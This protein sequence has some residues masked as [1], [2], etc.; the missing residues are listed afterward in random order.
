MRFMMLLRSDASAESGALPD[1]K[2]LTDMTHYN[3]A[4]ADAGV[5]VGA[6]G[7]HPTSRGA[8]IR[9]ANG[10]TTVTD[11]PFAESKEV[12][13]GFFMLKTKSLDE[14]IS[15]AKRMPGG[16]S[17][18]EGRV[19]LRQI[20][21]T[22]DFPV[23]PAEKEGGWRDEELAMR[24]DP[25]KSSPDKGKRYMSFLIA[26]RNTEAEMMPTEKVLSEMGALVG[27]M[28]EKGVLISGE[29][30]RSSKYG[31]RLLYS[32][33]KVTVT[34]GPFAEAKE[35]I[36]GFTVF[37]A[38]TKAEAI[39]WARRGLQIHVEGTGIEAGE[40]EVREVF[41]TDDIPVAADEQQGGWRDQEKQLREKLAGA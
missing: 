27:E 35:L 41:E 32:K 19:E 12:V 34:D 1:Q 26:D 38:K 16:D 10:K 14:A 25:P 22:E 37:R 40:C 15:W 6:E 39:E 2:L 9:I 29:G 7:L 33:G 23:D 8:R 18:G 17:P 5:L 11:G 13:A 4:M 24:A 28:A 30:L 31:A 36:A 20:F 3:K 21:E